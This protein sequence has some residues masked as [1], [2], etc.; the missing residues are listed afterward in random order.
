MLSR[1]LWFFPGVI[2]SSLAAFVLYAGTIG[3]FIFTTPLLFGFVL[4][5]IYGKSDKIFHVM[6]TIPDEYKNGLKKYGLTVKEVKIRRLRGYS[7]SDHLFE[8]EQVPFAVLAS[9]AQAL[10]SSVFAGE[11]L[12]DNLKQ[13]FNMGKIADA[14]AVAMG[15]EVIIEHTQQHPNEAILILADEGK[16]DGSFSLQVM[17]IYHCGQVLSYQDPRLLRQAIMELQLSGIKV[18]GFVGDAL[19]NTNG[20]TR[21]NAAKEATN[22][23]SLFSLLDIDKITS[24]GDV[25]PL[26]SDDSRLAGITYSAPND[27]GVNPLDLPSVALMKIAKTHAQKEGELNGL[28]PGMPG[29]EKFEYEY[30]T[31]FINRVNLTLLDLRP[32][33]ERKPTDPQVHR[34]HLIIDDARKLQESYPSLKIISVSD[35]DFMP[36]VVAALGIPEDDEEGRR[37][38]VVFGRSGSA[39]GTAAGLVAEAPQAFFPRRYVSQIA[40]NG[41]LSPDTAHFDRFADQ[42]IRE[43]FDELGIP[44]S[45]PENVITKTGRRGIVAVTA[46]TGASE[47]LFGKRFASLMQRVGFKRYSGEYGEVRVN[48]LLVARDGSSFVVRTTFKSRDLVRTKAQIRRAS[49]LSRR[50]SNALVDQVVSRLGEAITMVFG[51]LAGIWQASHMWLSVFLAFF[52]ISHGSVVSS[53]GLEAAS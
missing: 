27:A 20:L 45:V 5:K 38:R 21:S 33:G 26:V 44:R 2:L 30:V 39:E 41:S 7:P 51:W 22:S 4:A 23:W 43:Q 18:K 47:G 8:Q 36:R 11:Q 46:V 12:R 3:D 42:E 6:S 9:Q 1:Q 25:I 16:R 28:F 34:H 14:N 31:F 17:S 37:F 10:G 15:Q 29:Y 32:A 13:E 53:R 19:E 35:G 48:T 24:E 50:Y 49:D 40:T 52:S